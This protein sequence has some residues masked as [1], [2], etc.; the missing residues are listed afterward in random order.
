MRIPRIYMNQSIAFNEC[1]TA[2]S[3]VA[4]YVNT[5]LRMKVGRQVILFNGHGGEYSATIVDSN[6]KTVSFEIDNFN[7]VQL[8]S[9]LSIELACCLIKSDRMDWL[10]QKATELGVTSFVPLFS[11][12]TDI[13]IPQNRLKKK[14]DHWQQVVVSAC[15]QSGRTHIPTVASPRGLNAWIEPIKVDKKIILHPYEAQSLDSTSNENIHS[16]ALLVGPEGGLTDE[17]V[18]LAH[19]YSFCSISLGPRILR[20]ETAPLAALSIIQHEFGDFSSP[21][22]SP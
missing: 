2:G 14:V 21:Q 7:D 6:K 13:K 16:V 3:T 10:L 1:F 22:A 15:E 5:V 18:A 8:E 20:A 12:C 9:P 4:H 17:E 11:E 19:R